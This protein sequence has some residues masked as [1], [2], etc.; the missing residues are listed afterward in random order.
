MR[1]TANL[2]KHLKRFPHYLEYI[3]QSILYEYISPLD[4][5]VQGIYSLNILFL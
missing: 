3:E 4:I 5:E 1:Q 2:K